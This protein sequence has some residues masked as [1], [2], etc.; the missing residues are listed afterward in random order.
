MKAK[1]GKIK[2][3]IIVT[4][5]ISLTS[6][7]VAIKANNISKMQAEIARNSVLPSFNID[8]K[9]KESDVFGWK[10]SSIIEISNLSGKMN[11]YQA[12]VITF[13][14]CG[15][16]ES[17]LADYEIVDIPIE[18]YYI[19]GVKYGTTN[20]IIEEK[21]TLGNYDKV[22]KLEEAIIQFNRANQNGQ[23]INAQVQSYLKIT[24]LDLLNENQ[25][26][27]YLI[28]PIVVKMISVESG[29]F[30][31]D[32]YNKLTESKFTI[33][34]NRFDEISV[35]EVID[36]IEGIL[37]SDYKNLVEQNVNMMEERELDILNEPIMTTIVGAI[38][39]IFATIFGGWIVYAREKRSQ[40]SFAATI[41]Y[42]DLKSIEKYLACER[43]SVNL[44]YSSD[45]QHMVAN[46]SFLKD[47]E[48][49]WIYTIYDEVYNYNYRYRLKEQMGNFRK[50]DIDPYKTLQ[51]NLFDTSK[52]YP[53]LNKYSEIYDKLIK[54]LQEYKKH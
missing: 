3:E 22:K 33:N 11:N 26:I 45:W 8:E 53:D 7:F 10:E 30:Q 48:V 24:Y 38:I 42:N 50:E 21:E 13:L 51:K 27:Y 23:S 12:K 40:E 20:G 46:C 31:F 9:I 14:H 25:E 5:I 34:P 1:L 44:R 6:V 36:A 37:S 19:M 4:V 18:S 15:Y 28:D 54:N 41:L 49:E 43:S 29:Q 17:E 39:G 47:E 16:F 35:N 52:G 2:W 32:K